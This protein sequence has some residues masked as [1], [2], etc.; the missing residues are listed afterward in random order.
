MNS[1]YGVETDSAI[2]KT[3][4]DE[5]PFIPTQQPC[6]GTSLAI[7]IPTS[8]S[9]FRAHF[10]RGAVD[11]EI[12]KLWWVAIVLGVLAG[13]L[14]ARFAPERLFKIVFV[15]VAWSAATRLILSRDN[16]KF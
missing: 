16:W 15:C 3:P 10:E 14:T 7:I 5:P 4:C 1:I 12:L 6:I 9:S 13:S 2:K 8:I 11:M